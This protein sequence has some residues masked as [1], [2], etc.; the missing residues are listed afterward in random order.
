MTPVALGS[1]LHGLGRA[2]PNGSTASLLTLAVQQA[3]ILR[4]EQAPDHG[5]P[6]ASIKRLVDQ[7]AWQR[8]LT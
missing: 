1:G 7:G 2:Q 6:C 8:L 4:A 3:G 5:L